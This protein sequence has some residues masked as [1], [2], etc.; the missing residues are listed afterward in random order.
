MTHRIANEFAPTGFVSAINICFRRNSPVGAGLLANGVTHL[1]FVDYFFLELILDVSDLGLAVRCGQAVFAQVDEHQLFDRQ[2]ALAGDLV[3]YLTG[4]RDRGAA[5]LC[6]GDAQFD[7]V[8]LTRGADEIDL[9]NVLGDNPLV[10]QLNDGVDRRLFID[11][12]QQTAAEQGA[13]SVEVFGFYPF[14]GVEIHIHSIQSVPFEPQASSFKPQ[15]A[16]QTPL[17]AFLTRAACHLPLKP[18]YNPHRFKTV[19]FS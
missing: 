6:G 11:P 16:S 15:A 1:L 8:A 14:A 9:G 3:A 19:I 13:V 17:S 7:D 18:S 4:Q 10:A 2:N 12:A 5:K